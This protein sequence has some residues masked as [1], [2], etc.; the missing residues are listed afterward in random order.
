MI[1]VF[2]VWACRHAGK[3]ALW[4]LGLGQLKFPFGEHWTHNYSTEPG[5]HT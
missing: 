5:N 3:S 2:L 1:A 4:A